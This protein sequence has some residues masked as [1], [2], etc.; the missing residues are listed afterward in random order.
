MGILDDLS[1]AKS[2][3]ALRSLEVAEEI[4]DNI[5]TFELQIVSSK[6]TINRMHS[7]FTGAIAKKKHHIEIYQK[8]IVRLRE[9]Y[10]KVVNNS[11]K[12]LNEI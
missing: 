8:C 10:I 7:D 4:V 5:K 11:I 3:K 9:R 1:N 2:N 12:Q 6:D